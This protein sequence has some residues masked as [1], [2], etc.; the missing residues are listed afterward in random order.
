MFLN[1]VK[2]C[3]FVDKRNYLNSQL[4][5]AAASYFPIGAAGFIGYIDEFRFVT[6]VAC[7]TV[8]FAP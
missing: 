6:G 5:V 3:E 8:D 2:I 1:G 4:V 7:P